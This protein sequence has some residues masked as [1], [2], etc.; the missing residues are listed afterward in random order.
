MGDQ[1][2]ADIAAKE[3]AIARPGHLR[4]EWTADS[5]IQYPS[6]LL[7]V[8]ND[9]YHRALGLSSTGAKRVLRSIA[10]Y[11]TPREDTKALG[12]GQAI[13][14]A[15][16]EPHKFADEYAIKVPVPDR[17][18]GIKFNTKEG[19]AW[20]E[21]P[22]GLAWLAAVEVA[23]AHNQ[24]LKDG[25]KIA[26]NQDLWDR[27]HTMRDVCHNHSRLGVMLKTGDPEVAF[28]ANDPQYDIDV[29]CKFD[30]LT[31]RGVSIDIKSTIN[32]EPHAFMKAFSNYGYH[33][34]DAFYRRVYKLVTGEDLREFVFAALEKDAPHGLS[35]YM[36]SDD[37]REEGERLMHQALEIYAEWFHSADRINN[38]GPCYPEHIQ[39]LPTPSWIKKS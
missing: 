5:S 21:S 6:E 12:D 23:E 2:R 20:K 19:K 8:P 16:L 27:C 31:P 18:D 22:Q 30:W 38:V 35:L 7:G 25:R 36:L 29:R 4:A 17:P 1:A 33:I 26:I 34:S 13:H 37:W 15:T 32:A 3:E 24:Q 11:L 9:V 28:F 10:H 39:E 14:T